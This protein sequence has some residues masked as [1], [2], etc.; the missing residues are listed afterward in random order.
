MIKA[1]LSPFPNLLGAT[2]NARS[3]FYEVFQREADKYD[4]DI[5]QDHNNRINTGLALVSVFCASNSV[6]AL[7]WVFPGNRLVR[8]S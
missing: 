1:S 6:V 3:A 7:I 8:P 4:R 2:S 5:S